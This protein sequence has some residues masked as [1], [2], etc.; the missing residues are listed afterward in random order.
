[1]A[2]NPPAPRAAPDSG[3]FID[4][5]FPR[6]L[7]GIA[8]SA[9]SGQLDVREK[10]PQEGGKILKR[11]M[12]GGGQFAVIGGSAFETLPEILVARGRLTAE[13]YQALKSEAGGDYGQMEQ[14]VLSGAVVPPGELAELITAQVSVKIKNLFPMIR[15]YYSFKPQPMETLAA[16]HVMLPLDMDK[17]IMEAVAEHYPPVR[18]KKEFPAIEK[19]AFAVPAGTKDRLMRFGFEPPLLRWLRAMDNGFTWASLLRNSP[20]KE[21]KALPLLLALYFLEL[22]S[23]PEAEEDFPLGHAYL[24]E[25]PARESKSSAR[26]TES[27]AA[28]APAEAEKSEP[29]P[30]APKAEEPKLP[31]EELL[32]QPIK[33]KELLES[34]DR[35]L[36]TA[37]KRESTHFDLLGVTETTPAEKVKKIY[38]KIAKRYHPDARPDLFQ[39]PMKEKV[40]DLF[41]KIT[42][43][44][45]VVTDPGKRAAYLKK[46][47]VKEPEV[48]VSVGQRALEAEQEF[49]MAEVLIRRSQWTAAAEKLDR[50]IK[51]YDEPEFKVHLAWV[52]YKIKGPAETANARKTIKDIVDKSPDMPAGLF[53]LAM[54]EKNDGDL[55][56]AE[57]YLQKYLLKRPHDVDAKRELQLLARKKSAPPP[58]KKGFFGKG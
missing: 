30:P 18:I 48:D 41:G 13:A 15:G 35:M 32:D 38:Y 19:K 39:G 23:L 12:I 1:M 33:D 24:D 22:I 36:A 47:K 3:D 5:P 9:R 14:K 29:S 46:I 52:H 10:S 34:I 26:P 45:E 53:F 44:Y 25:K 51:L 49:A 20:L 6:V 31:M 8:R 54:L 28:A 55:E 40:E 16:K 56:K 42:E 2:A 11:I 50:A 7:A 21:D 37:K 58:K 17:L 57:A 27:K 43:A 4:H